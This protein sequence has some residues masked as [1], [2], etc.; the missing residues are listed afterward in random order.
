MSKYFITFLI[1][2]NC[3]QL[4][5]ITYY[6]PLILVAQMQLRQQAAVSNEFNERLLYLT[7]PKVMQ[8]RTIDML[9]GRGEFGGEQQ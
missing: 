8:D 6:A 4:S 7:H 9:V 2:A 5:F 1:V 3:M